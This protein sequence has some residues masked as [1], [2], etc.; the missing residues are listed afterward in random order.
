MG[1]ADVTNARVQHWFED[2]ILSRACPVSVRRAVW[3]GYDLGLSDRQRAVTAELSR[4]TNFGANLIGRIDTPPDFNALVQAAVPESSRQ[5]D[6]SRQ[7]DAR[8]VSTRASIGGDTI[9]RSV[10][11]MGPPTGRLSHSRRP[12]TIQPSEARRPSTSRPSTNSAW[13]ISSDEDREVVPRSSK[14]GQKKK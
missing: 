6:R 12:S 14:H 13:D 11:S 7:V 3:Y 8:E 5:R 9:V 4:S 2:Q 1:I 10:E